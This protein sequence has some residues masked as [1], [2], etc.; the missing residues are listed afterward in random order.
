MNSGSLATLLKNLKL[1]ELEAIG[2]HL[3]DVKYMKDIFIKKLISNLESLK[4][5]QQNNY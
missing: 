4:E 1:E 5:R 2:K 3:K